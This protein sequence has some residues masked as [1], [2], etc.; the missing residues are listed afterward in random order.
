MSPRTSL[1]RTSRQHHCCWVLGMVQK[2]TCGLWHEF[3]P[4]YHGWKEPLTIRLLI[5]QCVVGK[6]YMVMVQWLKL[7]PGM[8]WSTEM[9]AALRLSAAPG[10]AREL[11]FMYTLWCVS[12]KIDDIKISILSYLSW[13][14]DW[15]LMRPCSCQLPWHLQ[16]QNVFKQ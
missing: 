12:G 6:F 1:K 2:Y 8:L 14:G 3:M 5:L 4:F 11:G 9:E 16:H 7:L 15:S 13:T 10:P